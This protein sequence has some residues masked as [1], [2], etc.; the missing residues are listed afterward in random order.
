MKRACHFDTVG[1]NN[2]NVTH[3]TIH[4]AL[5]IVKSMFKKC[6]IAFPMLSE[7]YSGVVFGHGVNRDGATEGVTCNVA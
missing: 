4:E 6:A 5:N 3:V 2:R 1:I 7:K